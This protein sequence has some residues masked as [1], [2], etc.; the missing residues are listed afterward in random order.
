M[1]GNSHARGGFSERS[2][3]DRGLAERPFNGALPAGQIYELRRY[4]QHYAELS[5]L[6]SALVVID[7]LNFLDTPPVGGAFD[8]RRL[9]VTPDG[10]P[11]PK[12][13]V[14][15]LVLTNLTG[16][17]L[18]ASFGALFNKKRAE[19]LFNGFRDCTPEATPNRPKRAVAFLGANYERFLSGAYLD[20]AQEFD[21]RK[22]LAAMFEEARRR[23]IRLYVVIPPAHATYYIELEAAG[24]WPAYL[25]I[26]EEAVRIAERTGGNI[27]IYD[28]TGFTEVQTE[29]LR[30]GRPLTYWRDTNH[31]SCH[32][33]DLIVALLSGQPAAAAD[34]G[35]RVTMDNLPAHFDRIEAEK[36]AWQADE[37][38]AYCGYLD[39]MPA[40]I[41]EKVPGGC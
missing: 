41:R 21:W 36:R 26:V 23:D 32:T 31:F 34:F 5:E 40:A 19:P 37:R 15:D 8:E 24:Y 2:F 28:F 1:L 29:P 11:N 14:S 20:E 12:W 18:Q 6:R 3:L 33:G 38:A 27:E 25:S 17:G 9:A 10:Q 22:E 39:M 16:A 7:I 30:K 13:W 4:F 35:R